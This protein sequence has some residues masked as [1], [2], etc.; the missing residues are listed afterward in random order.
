MEFEASDLACAVP[1]A[2]DTG[3]EKQIFSGLSISLNTGEIVDLVGPSGS[4]KSMLLTTLAALNPYGHGKMSID[5][6]K[7]SQTT[8]QLWRRKV[9]YLP[10]RPTLGSGSVRDAIY[11]PFTLLVFKKATAQSGNVTAPAD[12]D[13]RKSLDELGLRDVELDRPAQDLS[14]G[15][16]ARVCLLRSVLTNP[17]VLLC[18]EVDAGLDEASAELVSYM[19]HQ[20]SQN[21]MIILR[22]RHH[23]S[24]G[25]AVRTL[26]LAD[27]VLSEITAPQGNDGE[28][29]K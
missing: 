4:G 20:C 6:E 11:F 1:D 27:G 19:L 5:D 24:D 17:E 22:V 18:D 15:Q 7:Y 3:G 23:G 26:Q 29:Q 2:H 16:Q 28:R 8:P 9:M 14:V 12:A 10:Q 13:I 25:L 21:G